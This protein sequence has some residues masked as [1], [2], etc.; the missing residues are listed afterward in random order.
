MSDTPT[1]VPWRS[2]RVRNAREVEKN[3]SI[4]LYLL[5]AVGG[6]I[7]PTCLNSCKRLHIEGQKR[8]RMGLGEHVMEESTCVV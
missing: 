4:E 7:W 2:T 1:E 3:K 6:Y 5:K 8:V